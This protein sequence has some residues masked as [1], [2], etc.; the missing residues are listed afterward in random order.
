MKQRR[1]LARALASSF[2]FALA[3][4]LSSSFSFARAHA[5]P[6]FRVPPSTKQLIVVVTD[7]W[8]DL[9]AQLQRFARKGGKW[10]REGAAQKV[11]TGRAGLGWGIGL[12]PRDVESALGGPVKHEG[13]GRAPAGAFRLLEATGYAPS[14]PK[15]TTLKYRQA[16]ARLRCVDDEKSPQYNLLVEEPEAGPPWSSAEKMHRDDELYTR[17]IVVE[18]NRQPPEPGRGS[19]I[20][21]H[22][23]AG[24]EVGTAGCTA[25][26]A[27]ELES[28]LAWLRADAQPLFVALPREVYAKVAKAWD[29]PP[30]EN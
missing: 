20:F 26:P 29:L 2:A 14:P 17:A 22:V 3:F 1:S 28:L 16:D 8:D 25:L 15:G 18:H 10:R 21:V 6:S 19:C 24:P 9:H 11:V 27:P 12:Q 30:L 23:W 5:A 13:D 4:A 7:G